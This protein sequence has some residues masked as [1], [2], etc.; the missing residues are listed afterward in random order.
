MSVPARLEQDH[1]PPA[2]FDGLSLDLWQSKF[3]QAYA[4]TGSITAASHSA[5]VHTSYHYRWVKDC[6]DYALGYELARNAYAD[7]AEG[8]LRR[9]GVMG[10][11]K[12]LSYKGKL[13]G[14][15]IR[16]Y[17]DALMQAAIKALKPEYRDGQQLTVGPTKISIEISAPITKSDETEIVISPA[18]SSD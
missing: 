8:E 4:D 9:R 12:P 16:E 2:L 18:K 14:D 5:K 11:D 7:V 10:W 15:K 6:A 13:T 3:L 1:G 17:S